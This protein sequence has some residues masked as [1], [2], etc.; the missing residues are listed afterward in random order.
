MI[1]WFIW[2]ERNVRS[3][4]YKVVSFEEIIEFI[5]LRLFWWIKGWNDDFLYLLI[6]VVRNLECLKWIF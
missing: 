6:D 3:I 4:E 5:F 2:N 1:N